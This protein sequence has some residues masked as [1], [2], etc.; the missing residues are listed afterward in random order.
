MVAAKAATPANCQVTHQSLLWPNV[1]HPQHSALSFTTANLAKQP[2][3]STASHA[4]FAVILGIVDC[5]CLGPTNRKSCSSTLPG[6]TGLAYLYTVIHQSASFISGLGFCASINL[7]QVMLL[8]VPCRHWM[9]ITCNFYLE[10]FT[11][12]QP[13]VTCLPAK[14]FSYFSLHQTKPFPLW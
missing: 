2:P 9:S 8:V 7:V 11:T 14:L 3:P 10:R 1:S 4:S 5:A 13:P 12:G 6:F